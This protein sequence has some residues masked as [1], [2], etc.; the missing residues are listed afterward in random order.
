M[1]SLQRQLLGAQRG[2]VDL[3]HVAAAVRIQRVG[4]RLAGRGEVSSVRLPPRVRDPGQPP[5]GDVEQRHILVA[6][7]RIRADQQGLAVRRQRGRDMQ[8]VALVRREVGALASR[9]IDPE[10]I[11]VR[12]RD[13]GPIRVQ[14]LAVCAPGDGTPRTVGRALVGQMADFAAGPVQ[15]REIGLGPCLR[16]DVQRDG[17][18]VRRPARRHLGHVGRVRQVHDVAA[19]TGDGKDVPQLIAAS[20]LLVHDPLAVG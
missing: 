17:P 5:G 18:T 19:I 9:D 11:A 15:Q 16:L 4:Q 3:V 6:T 20:I 13:F 1:T 10:H 2:D 7:L 14:G 12:V 8:H